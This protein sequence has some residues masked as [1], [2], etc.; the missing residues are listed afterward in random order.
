MPLLLA[1][2]RASGVTVLQQSEY[3][4]DDE[5]K[6]NP[7]ACAATLCCPA[8]PVA[9]LPLLPRCPA[10]PLPRG[11]PSWPTANTRTARRASTAR[12]SLLCTHDPRHGAAP[13]L[14]RYNPSSLVVELEIAPVPP[15]T[16]V[17][18]ARP[19]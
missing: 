1:F 18:N 16:S 2:L 19:A 14:H 7:I 8:A 6:P 5:Y 15:A 9:L 13:R 10:V 17:E 3:F 12:A 4:L 11:V